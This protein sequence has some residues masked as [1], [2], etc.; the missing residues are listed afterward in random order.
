ML[1]KDDFGCT[2]NWF[3]WVPSPLSRKLPF[4][5]RTKFWRGGSTSWHRGNSADNMMHVALR[6]GLNSPYIEKNIMQIE[7]M[8]ASTRPC[9]KNLLGATEIWFLLFMPYQHITDWK[10][11]MH[12]S[13]LLSGKVAVLELI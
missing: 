7:T 1:K 8:I 5:R 13:S 4:S 10:C 3:G 2:T 11:I 12:Y 6:Y 9:V